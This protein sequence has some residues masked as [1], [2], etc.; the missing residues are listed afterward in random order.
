M[1]AFA[2]R[3]GTP[4]M[5]MGPEALT[6]GMRAIVQNEVH[7]E[8]AFVWRA[9]LLGVAGEGFTVAE[10]SFGMARVGISAVALGG[11]RRCAQL[12]HRY[13]SRRQINTGSLLANA[14]TRDVLASLV[15]SASAAG[16]LL[17][18]TASHETPPA[19]LAAICKA[20]VPELLWQVTDRV[21]QLLGGRG[22]I[23]TNELP[24]IVRDARLLRIFEGP[25]ETLEMHLGSAVLGN[26][27]SI[28]TLFEP[29]AA[30]KA[31]AVVE[32]WVA[33][34][35]A[36]IEGTA[37]DARIAAGQR[38]KLAV[39]QVVAWGVLAAA[40]EAEPADALHD[41]A[42]RWALAE[43]ESRAA[44]CEP[45]VDPGVVSRAIADYRELIGDVEQSLPGADHAL[46]PLL[47]REDRA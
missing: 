33:K 10:D 34:A 11:L 28:D 15:A 47:R 42:R 31:R 40:A 39:G 35:A 9:D 3:A 46:D 19:H 6:T 1:C 18:I 8:D 17:R 45:S 37:G 16:S 21:T 26:A 29:F 7:L 4:G 2:V 32:S 36:Q 14:R 38:A 25:T 13:A 44:R 27:F 20:V 12:A 22:Y 23:E 41:L 43:L 5:R 30:P 24:R